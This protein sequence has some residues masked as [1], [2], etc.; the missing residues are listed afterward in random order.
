MFRQSFKVYEAVF[1]FKKYE[2]FEK[3]NYIKK[4][5]FH[6]KK[7][8]RNIPSKCSNSDLN[9]SSQMCCEMLK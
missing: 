6:R 1:A 8:S 5:T 7:K 9:C 3:K 2:F 4:F